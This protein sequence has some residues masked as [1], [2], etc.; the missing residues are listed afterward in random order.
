[1]ALK[2]QEQVRNTDISRDYIDNIKDI[3]YYR[4]D[5]HRYYMF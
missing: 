3:V 5:P 4:Y 2:E 1:M